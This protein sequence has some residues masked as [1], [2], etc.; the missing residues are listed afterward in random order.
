MRTPD[1]MVERIA[2]EDL[3]P[4]ELESARRRLLSEPDGAERLAALK[5][6]D[7][8]ILAGLPPE[9]VAAEVQRRTHLAR[10]RVRTASSSPSARSPSPLLAAFTVAALLLVLFAFLSGD[11]GG[12]GDGR[13]QHEA[14]AIQSLE[15]SEDSTRIKGIGPTLH[16]QRRE[17]GRAVSLDDGAP[18]QAGDLLQLGY[19]AAGAAHGV[20]LSIDGTGALTQHLPESGQQSVPLQGDGLQALPHAFELDEAPGFERFF[21]VTGDGPFDAAPIFEAARALGRDGARAKQAPLPL[22]TGL[23]QTSLLLRKDAP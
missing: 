17:D 11:D 16:A 12:D 9:Q 21:L 13:S 2:L 15:P 14:L 6:S 4:G 20:I 5:R 19:V 7:A 10:V 18:V 3:P 23:R 8:E 1:W 22:P